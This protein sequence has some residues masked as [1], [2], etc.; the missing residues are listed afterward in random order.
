MALDPNH[1][2]DAAQREAGGKLSVK[3]MKIIRT[4]IE[5]LNREEQ[6]HR[7]RADALPRP[8]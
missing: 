3:D 8:S 5:D 7:D 1:F 6:E 2:V 4:F